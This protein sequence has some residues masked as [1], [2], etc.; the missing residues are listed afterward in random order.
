MRKSLFIALLFV[1][2]SLIRGQEIPNGGFEQWTDEFLFERP[3]DWDHGNYQDA[4][5]V[6][7]TKAT[8]APEGQYAAH[9]ETQYYNGD[10]AFGYV[11]LGRIDEMPVAGV[12]HGTDVAAV[13]CWLRYDLQPGDT[14]LALAVCWSGGAIVS[15][16]EW[17]FQGQQTSWTQQTFTLPLAA[18]NVDS[19]VVGFASTDPFTSGIARQGS[20]VEV[21]EVRLTHPNVPNPDVL[22]NAGF[23]A[24]SD[25]SAEDPDGWASFNARVA[26]FGFTSVIKSPD[27]NSGSFSAMLSTIG[28]FGDTLPAVLTNGL[29]ND[30][31]PYAGI[32]YV[33]TPMQFTGAYKYQPSG[34]DEAFI[35]VTFLSGG[36]PIGNALRQIPAAAATWTPF[37]VNVNI[38]GGPPDSMLVAAFSGDNPGS[39]LWVDDLDLSGGDVG[40]PELGRSDA[41]PWPNPALDRITVPGLAP[42]DQVRIR[43]ASGRVVREQRVVLAGPAV[44]ELG[45]LTPGVYLVEVRS[46]VD[47]SAHRVIKGPDRP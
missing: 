1:L 18:I 22:P 3:D 28:A 2:P 15:S 35:G 47:V 36:V 19:V 20:W 43:D 8:G 27:A 40:V 44:F 13:E 31:G 24:W 30:Q 41:L 9:L 12:P 14:A 33:A 25:V 11:L 4:P 21:D 45:G 7:T 46:G 39:T 26:G 5:V 37:S 23:E 17:R 6:T 16:G 32:P 38:L 34:V 42:G 10:T 29:L